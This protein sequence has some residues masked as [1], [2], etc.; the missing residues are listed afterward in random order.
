MYKVVVVGVRMWVQSPERGIRGPG[1]GVTGR[2]KP[3]TWVLGEVGSL[4]E[5]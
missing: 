2:F 4:Q 1:A 3:M 5:Q